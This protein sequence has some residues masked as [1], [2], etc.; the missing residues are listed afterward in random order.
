MAT[1][2]NVLNKLSVAPKEVSYLNKSFVDFKGD[3]IT[4]TKNYYPTT[5]T[6]FNEAN[7]GMIMLELAAYVGDVLS[8]YVDNQFKENLL[9]YA[10][11]EGNVITIAQALGYKPKTIVP[12]TAEILISQVVPAL[13]SADGYIPDETYFLKID[14]NSTVSTLP[15]NVVTFRT[16][17]LVDFADPLNR[18][19]VPRQLDSTTLLPITYLVT[20]KVKVVA[21]D[22]RQETFTFGDPEKFSTITIGDTNITS[23]SE[24]LDADG[25]KWYEVDYLAQDTIVD[26][27]EVTYI[28]S[29]SESVAP[30][31]A[32][33][34]RTVP[35]R[36]VTRL[37]ID[38]KTELVFGSGRGNV[39]EDV[40]YLDS[41]QVANSEY[42]TQL[43][44]VSLSNTD[45]L[46]T[47]NFG[48]APADTTL[49]VTYFTGG[50][51]DSNVASGTI[52]QVGQMNV[53]NRTTELNQTELELFNDI[54]NTITVYNE[55]PA[56]GGQDGETVEE[57]R[58]RA[59]AIYSAQNRIVTRRDYEARVLAMPAKYGSVTKVFAISDTLQ[60]RIQAEGTPEQIDEN[61]RQ[62]VENN[63]KPNAINL[64][65]LGYNQNK[66]ISTVNDLV[67]K[68]LQQ[69]L[70]QYR[71]LTDQV[72]ILDA[73]TVN[74]GVNF[75]ITVFKN[76]NMG[77]TVALCLGAIKDY[78]DIDKWNIN[79]PIRL[80][81]L[82]LLLQA[83][84]GVQSVNRLEITNKYFFKDGR[85]YQPY[86]YDI[87]EA[88]VDNVVYP[89]LDPCIFEIRYP[90]DDI[91][92]SAR[93]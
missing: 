32:I 38:K 46:N 63:P 28:A 24:V 25:Y 49:T 12:A 27:K 48:I 57:I 34:Y 77:D 30:S 85:D 47:D 72:N 3:L 18:V 21:G 59:L 36:F 78:F 29:V 80:G 71:M 86:R 23:I 37:T 66:K 50:G 60:S 83:Q 55:M 31:Y 93:Q 70:S 53:L 39:S 54:V 7:P 43:A 92:G 69:Y 61:I 81:D 65:V 40:V 33:K 89:S 20:K 79:Q 91:V 84:D 19:I 51:V 10:E 45:L 87:T 17:E 44:S 56:T 73:F 35:R 13:G 74:I 14:K 62:F 16:T 9:A 58:Q 67:K 2:N 82:Q 68:N 76:Y 15:P 8:F 4:F 26:D 52:V 75:D 64:Y 6:D 1:T 11:E 90:E 41:Q 42:G 5:W 22:I 88:T